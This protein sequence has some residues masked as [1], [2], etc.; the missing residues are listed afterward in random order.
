MSSKHEQILANLAANYLNFQEFAKTSS[1]CTSKSY[2]SDLNQFLAPLGVGTII[3]NNEK[4][5]L[6]TKNG[7]LMPPKI[8]KHNI[9]LSSQK[10]I[11]LVRLAQKR[12]ASLAP[13]SRNR[14]SACLKSFF[15]WLYNEELLRADLGAQIICQKVPQ[16]MPHF[17]SM[18]E[19]LSLVQFLT[20]SKSKDRDRDLALILLL[21]GGGLR[22]SEACNLKW[23]ELDLS[24]RTIVVKGKGG[25]ERKVALVRLLVEALKRLS[26]NSKYVFSSQKDTEPINTRVAYEIVRRSGAQA[27]LMKPLHPHALRHSFATHMLSSGTDLRILQELLGHESLT[28]TQ[29]YLHLSIDSLARTMEENHPFGRNKPGAL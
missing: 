6:S 3:F 11:G 28:A 15:R 5:L 13:A 1:R 25:K 4:W 16:K 29:K 26:R 21:Y 12:W 14:K 24:T 7:H 10:L 23:S 22:V 27:G 20:N 9:N 17:L 2:A 19:A 18:D 8:S